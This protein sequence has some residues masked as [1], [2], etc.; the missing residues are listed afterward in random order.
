MFLEEHAAQ[1]G[2]PVADVVRA[3]MGP[4]DF[5]LRVVIKKTLECREVGA[6][7]C[8]I[9]LGSQRGRDG[10]I[11]CHHIKMHVDG[12]IVPGGNIGEQ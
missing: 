4:T 7:G 2:R 10:N 6:Q 5:R 11:L 8:R 3:G 1:I 9:I 12:H